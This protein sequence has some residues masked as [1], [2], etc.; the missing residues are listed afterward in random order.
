MGAL[1]NF[2]DIEGRVL[3]R[4]DGLATR[5]LASLDR[6]LRVATE[7][8]ALWGY[9]GDA[10]V[11][12]GRKEEAIASYRK[13]ASLSPDDTDNYEK[14]L[15]LLPQDTE[16]WVRK[17]EAHARREEAED[18]LRAFDRALRISPDRVEAWAGKASVHESL[19]QLD[20]ALRCIDRALGLDDRNAGLWFRRA[21]ILEKT[22]ARDEAVKSFDA[23]LRSEEHTSELQSHSDLVCRLL[24]EKK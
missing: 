10:A 4:A 24:L 5:G 21:G 12:A 9:R 13:V 19:S 7:A 22:G 2:L 15:K 17:A 20:R 3:R 18:A 1:A 8:R 23:S 16:L 6:A 11:A 14:I